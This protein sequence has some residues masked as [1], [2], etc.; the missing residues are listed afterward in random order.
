MT[1]FLL[2]LRI[3]RKCIKSILQEGIAILLCT[4]TFTCGFRCF[5][6][7]SNQVFGRCPQP[8]HPHTTPHSGAARQSFDHNGRHLFAKP[9]NFIPGKNHYLLLLRF[10]A[11]Q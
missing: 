3:C 5:L 6:S 1:S 2:L 9:E 4:S 8:K 7:E 10:A 11:V